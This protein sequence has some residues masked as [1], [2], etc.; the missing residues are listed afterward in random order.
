MVSI[1]SSFR[2]ICLPIQPRLK[3]LLSKSTI[4]SAKYSEI[5]DRMSINSSSIL[6]PKVMFILGGPGAGKGN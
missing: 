6:K 2:S 5:R 3:Y 4:A 1:V